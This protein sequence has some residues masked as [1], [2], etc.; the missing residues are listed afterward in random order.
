MARIPR[1]Y[2]VEETEVG[3]YHCINRCVRRAFLCGDDPVSGQ[4]FDHRRQWIRDR[5]EFLAGWFGVDVLGFAVMS[6]HLHVVLRNRPDVA[7]Q[8]SDEEV[9]RRWW[10]IFPQRREKDGAPAEPVES[11]LGMVV[12]DPERLAEVR[13]R[14]SNIGWFM[15][16]LAEPIARRANKE[17]DCTG[18]FFEGRYKCQPLLDEAAVAACMA[19]VDLNPVRAGV[20]Q[21]P[22]NSRFTSV[23]ERVAVRRQEDSTGEAE[24][25]SVEE[26]WLSPVELAN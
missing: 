13:R 26:G 23:F 24:A 20:A 11:D 1:K 8:W 22:E 16:C 21:T 7:T 4:N 6:N 9:A 18:R 2:V 12:N 14:L 10:M 3:V 5:L 25:F 19:Y 17:D 15:R